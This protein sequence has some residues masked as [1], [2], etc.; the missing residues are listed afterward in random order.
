MKMKHLRAVIVVLLPVAA[1]VAADNR[2]EFKYPT[3]P[4]TSITVVNEFGPVTLKPVAGR[5]ALII[6]TIHSDKVEVVCSQ[7]GN[8]IE[9]RTHFLQKANDDEGRVE[10][11]IA[12]PAGVAVVVRAATG[13]IEAEKLQGDVTLKGDAARVIA[14]DLNNSHVHIQ[15]VGGPIELNN[16]SGGHVEVISTDGAVRLNAVS[17]PKVSVNTASGDI[18][19]EGDLGSGGE[20][21]FSNH[22]GNIE[23]T[24]P[25]TASMDL[26]ARSITGSVQNEFPL[27]RK[28]RPGLSLMDGRSSVGTSNAGASSVQL[29]SFSGKIRVKKR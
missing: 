23:L 16:V 11:E 4:G 12:V 1:A 3:G 10:Y 22:S 17:G 29:R 19:Y 14:R 13:P 20:Y 6:A 27:E 26:M 15:T 18:T 24:L 5:Q 8:R 7:T 25:A 2:K 9:A 28:S 21:S